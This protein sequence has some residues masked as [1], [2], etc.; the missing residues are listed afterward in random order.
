MLK[1]NNDLILDVAVTKVFSEYHPPEF[2]K[3]F[4]DAKNGSPYVS[5]WSF[6]LSN[7]G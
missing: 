5:T 2:G 3:H 6:K 1:K 7:S 4:S